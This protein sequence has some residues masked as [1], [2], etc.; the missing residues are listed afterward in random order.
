M[1]NYWTKESESCST[2]M[3]FFD[4]TLRVKRC[5]D[6]SLV[7]A[8]WPDWATFKSFGDKKSFNSSTKYL[9]A[10]WLVCKTSLLSKTD[11]VIFGQP[12]VK[13]DISEHQVRF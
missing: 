13:I 2:R 7:D 1:D 6:K 5:N 10:F 11:V 12:V 9:V 4:D 3:K 8:V